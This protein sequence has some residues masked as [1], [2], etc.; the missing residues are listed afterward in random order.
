MYCCVEN[1]L[2]LGI[3]LLQFPFWAVRALWKLLIASHSGNFFAGKVEGYLPMNFN[4]RK[5]HSLYM[6]LETML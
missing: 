5:I 2:L 3:S 4:L 6:D 1:T